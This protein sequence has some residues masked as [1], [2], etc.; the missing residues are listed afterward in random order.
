MRQ[1]KV[2]SLFTVLLLSL[3]VMVVIGDTYATDC[4]MCTS[5]CSRTCYC[6][7]THGCAT[8]AAE[9]FEAVQVNTDTHDA[10]LGVTVGHKP[11][12]SIATNSSMLDR[13]IRVGQTGQCAVNKFAL[14]LLAEGPKLL[15][16]DQ[17]FASY[18]ES[19][20]NIIAFRSLEKY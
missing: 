4:C 12:A 8:C 20:G 9:D 6:P 18:R 3:S 2:I 15:K 19:Q 7:G 11:A 17:T 1:A 5:G 16:I 14:R 10:T 13:L